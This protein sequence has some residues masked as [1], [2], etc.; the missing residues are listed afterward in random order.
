VVYSWIYGWIDS[1]CIVPFKPYFQSVFKQEL[2]QKKRRAITN[3]GGDQNRYQPFSTP[4]QR[5]TG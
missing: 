2:G 3:K 1:V 5:G 4:T